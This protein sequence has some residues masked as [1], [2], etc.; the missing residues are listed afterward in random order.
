MSIPIG[1]SGSDRT[2]ADRN[3]KPRRTKPNQVAIIRCFC[4]IPSDVRASEVRLRSDVKLWRR[5]SLA[6][7]EL[8]VLNRKLQSNLAIRRRHPGQP[9]SR[10]LSREPLV[11]SCFDLNFSFFPASQH[12]LKS[13]SETLQSGQQ[14]RR[15]ENNDLQPLR[16]EFGIQSQQ[17]PI[18]IRAATH[19]Q[20]DAKY[21]TQAMSILCVHSRLFTLFPPSFHP[22]SALFPS[23]FR[24]LSTLFP[25]FPVWCS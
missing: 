21:A 7:I 22:L 5:R 6:S 1:C 10:T 13:A 12:R 23:S 24:P 17:L 18:D 15:A 4:G 14:L 9:A 2:A 25:P 11:S 3:P 20:H 19:K 8:Q 16:S